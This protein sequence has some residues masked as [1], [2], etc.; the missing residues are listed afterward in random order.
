[1]AERPTPPHKVRLT[2]VQETLLIPL[3]AKALDSRSKHPILGDKK[4]DEMVKAIDYEFW[5]LETPGNTNIL[6]VR[7]RQ[8][9][10][11]VREFVLANK[12]AI[13]I[14]LGCGLDS[15][16]SRI[17][18]PSDVSWFDVDFPQVIEVREKFFS[19]GPGYTMLGSSITEP[20]WLASVPSGRP[21]M[22]LADGVLEYLAPDEVRLLFN[23]L[24]ARF[25]RG[26]L[27]FDV[28]NSAAVKKGSAQL[29]RKI[30]AELKW[31]VDDVSAVD[32]MDPKLRRV[33]AMS[34]F[35]SEYFPSSYRMVFGTMGILRPGLR[36][37]IRL[38]RYDF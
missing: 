33:S 5:E 25:T 34:L 18:P 35:E 6:A 3:Y 16:V 32:A 11:W 15:R 21:V 26:Q 27:A 37:M 8:L 38:L 13:V 7:A 9:D 1:L 29:R 14:N 30:G 19:G 17:S 12:D 10:E 28:M 22:A 23:R 31:V 4:T 2:G 24:T 36:Q 20:G